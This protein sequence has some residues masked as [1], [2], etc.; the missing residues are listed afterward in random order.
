MFRALL[1]F[2]SWEAWLSLGLGT[3]FSY[4]LRGPGIL[5][6]PSKIKLVD[7]NPLVNPVLCV[8]KKAGGC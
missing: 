7:L 3:F 6:V 4:L 2:S 5:L 8:S 1:A